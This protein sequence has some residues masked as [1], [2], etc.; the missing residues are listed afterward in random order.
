M[1]GGYKF[2]N[3]NTKHPF[4]LKTSLQ[5]EDAS[6]YCDVCISRTAELDR[7]KCLL[8]TTKVSKENMY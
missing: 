4:G 7:N 3:R 8:L 6:H 5:M 2:Y 1:E